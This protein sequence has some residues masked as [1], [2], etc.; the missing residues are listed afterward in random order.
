MGY[1]TP[2]KTIDDLF[3]T[4]GDAEDRRY[5]ERKLQTVFDPLSQSNN[6]F[7]EAFKAGANEFLRSVFSGS[8]LEKAVFN[9]NFPRLSGSST[10]Q[11]F[12]K[13]P[14]VKNIGVSEIQQRDEVEDELERIDY[15]IWR[16]N[17]RTGIKEYDYIYKITQGQVADRIVKPN[18]VDDP[19]YRELSKSEQRKKM[20]SLFSGSLTHSTN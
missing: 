9:T 6:E 15:P 14:I 11:K 7:V 5:T 4:I 8:R 13:M 16:I 12:K 18:T 20:R 19:F 17:P 10:S 2:F 1:A 3:T